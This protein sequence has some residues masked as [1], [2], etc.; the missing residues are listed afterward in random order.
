MYMQTLANS[1]EPN[2]TPQNVV[3]DL[4][5]SCLQNAASDKGSLLDLP[6]N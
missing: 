5:L 3:S 6:L 4:V 1:L 2:Q